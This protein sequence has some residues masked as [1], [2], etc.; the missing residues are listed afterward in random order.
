[1]KLLLENL[2]RTGK[3]R[4]SRTRRIGLCDRGS[5]LDHRRARKEIKRYFGG[6][7][8]PFRRAYPAFLIRLTRRPQ[9][10][11]TLRRYSTNAVDTFRSSAMLATDWFLSS[12]LRNP[13]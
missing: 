7:T 13:M 10:L 5:C 4:T 9:S 2:S 12:A 6:G 1:M 11:V 3:S 8:N